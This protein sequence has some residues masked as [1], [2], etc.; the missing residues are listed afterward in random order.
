MNSLDVHNGDENYVEDFT[1][2]NQIEATMTYGYNYWLSSRYTWCN[3]YSTGW[4]LR[5]IETSSVQQPPTY[6][7]FCKIERATTGYSYDSQNYALRP[8]FLLKTSS[9][10]ITGGDGKGEATAYILGI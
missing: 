5:C 4:G 6:V 9:I 10:K 1:A 3:D 8:C 2:L 7:R